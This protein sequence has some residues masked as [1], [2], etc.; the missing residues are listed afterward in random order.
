M[1]RLAGRPSLPPTRRATR[2]R[3]SRICGGAEQSRRP[4]YELKDTRAPRAP[5]ARRSPQCRVCRTHSNLGNALH[6]LR[7]FDEAVVAY[8]AHRAQFELCR[9]WANLGPRCTIRQFRRRYLD[10]AARHR[11]A[12][13][14]PCALGSAFPADARRSRRRLGRIRMAIALDERKG[15]ISGNAVQGES[16]AGSTSMSSRAGFRRYAAIRPLHPFA[17]ARA[18][19]VTLRVHQQ[20]VS[21]LRASCRHNRLGDRGDPALSMRRRLLSLPRSFARLETIPADVPICMRRRMRCS[22]GPAGSA[23]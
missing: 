8:R 3:S 2:W 4:L 14:T 12:R 23:R 16:L 6:A 10:A 21:L 11:A 20:L 1:L 17:P 19:K 7:R 5:N 18:G 9:C 15:E 13:I 22:A